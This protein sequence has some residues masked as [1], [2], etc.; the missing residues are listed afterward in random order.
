MEAILKSHGF[1]EPALRL[2]FELAW[3]SQAMITESPLER[4]FS[5]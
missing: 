1:L 2:A 3:Q 5:E 4:Q